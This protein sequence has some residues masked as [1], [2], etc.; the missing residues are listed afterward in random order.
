MPEFSKPKAGRPPAIEL[1]SRIAAAIN[2]LLVRSDRS[3]WLAAIGSDQFGLVIDDT[4]EVSI[5]SRPA[6]AAMP[7]LHFVPLAAL[8]LDPWAIELGR[9]V[10][11]VALDLAAQAVVR[12]V[13]QPAWWVP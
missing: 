2:E 10:K 9:G 11:D 13:D 12:A 3:Q 7:A 6:V 5:V 1:R 8:N 4:Y